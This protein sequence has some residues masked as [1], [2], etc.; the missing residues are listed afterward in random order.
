[1]VHQRH[2][3]QGR[4]HE[5][6]RHHD[7]RV[8]SLARPGGNVTGF[9]QFDFSI[10]TKWLALLKT[11]A[12]NLTRVIVS[13]DVDTTGAGQFGAIQFAAQSIGVEVSPTRVRNTSDIENAVMEFTRFPNGGLVVTGS[14][15]AAA[16]W[17]L[18]RALSYVGDTVHTRRS[19]AKP[20]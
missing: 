6:G 8:A 15:P 18:I 3:L 17:N 19:G 16:H 5:A 4:A 20:R 12:P 9:T 14:A 1:V 10:T 2:A 7:P 13:R 11:V